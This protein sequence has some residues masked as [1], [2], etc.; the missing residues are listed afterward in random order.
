M[1]GMNRHEIWLK[2]PNEKVHFG[3]I[4]R[5]TTGNKVEMGLETA[6]EA[7]DWI[8]L[9]QDAVRNVVNVIINSRLSNYWAGLA[10]IRFSNCSS[11]TPLHGFQVRLLYIATRGK[12]NL[13][14]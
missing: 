14:K 4:Y 12:I 5:F 7:V 2:T 11:S 10:T 6:L 8:R 1:G 9:A 3:E 13:I